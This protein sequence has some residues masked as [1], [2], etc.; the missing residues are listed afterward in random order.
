MSSPQN[1]LDYKSC[2]YSV[3]LPIFNEESC[4][5][6][7]LQRIESTLSKMGEPFEIICVDDGSVDNSWA[8]ISQWHARNPS[9]KG[10]HF[11]RNFGHQLA[12]FAGIKYCIGNYIAIMDADGQDPPE[13]LPQLFEKCKQGYDVVCA[14]RKKRK[15]NILKRG[16][17]KLFYIIYQKF[18]PFP[19]PLDSGDFSVFTNNVAKFLRTLDEKRPFLRGLRSWVG[20]K[21]IG[22]EYE[23]AGRISGKPK[24]TLYKLVVLA[25]NGLISFSKIPLRTIS[26]LGIFTSVLS[27]LMGLGLLIL[28]FLIGINVPGWTSTAL[29]IIFFGGLNLL[30]LG[31]IGEYVGDIFDEV[32]N[33]PIFWID[34]S[35]GFKTPSVD[36]DVL[37]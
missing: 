7:V 15:E 14:I 8:I 32:K 3:I 9:V 31:I 4:L 1:A 21:Q 10:L 20:G 25:L 30:V 34:R 2:T 22:M 37:H 18:V 33:R 36:T 35:L 28:K 27:F 11:S 6:E 12:I 17:Y 13:I 26:L 19:V 23:R 29:L 24:Y 5:E 16:C